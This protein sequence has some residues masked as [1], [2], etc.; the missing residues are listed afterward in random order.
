MIRIKPAL[1]NR[2][3]HP[4]PQAPCS[5]E[6]LDANGISKRG[7]LLHLRKEALPRPLPAA[8]LCENYMQ[9]SAQCA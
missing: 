3:K 2:K 4:E 6:H 8:N 5:Q 1:A 9:P 7:E